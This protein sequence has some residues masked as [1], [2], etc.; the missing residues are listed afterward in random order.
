MRPSGVDVM[1]SVFDGVSTVS[2]GSLVHRRV[3][4]GCPRAEHV[5]SAD[6]PENTTTR[7][8]ER[9]IRIGSTNNDKALV[10]NRAYI[11]FI[12]VADNHQ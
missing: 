12:C 11:S 1:F 7:Y 3:G 5:I 4:G 8:R 2:V 6:S 10:V 9:E